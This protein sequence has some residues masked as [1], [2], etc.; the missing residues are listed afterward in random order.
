MPDATMIILT[1]LHKEKIFVNPA[2]IMCIA[3][4]PHDTDGHMGTRIHFVSG[5]VVNVTEPPEFVTDNF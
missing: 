5:D 4:C 2:S 3:Q 1:E